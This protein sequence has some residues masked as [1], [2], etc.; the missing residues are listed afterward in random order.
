MGILELWIYTRNYQ[1]VPSMDYLKWN[2]FCSCNL[3]GPSFRSSVW[4]G[5]FYLSVWFYFLLCQQQL[6]WTKVGYSFVDVSPI[7]KYT[8]LE[9]KKSDFFCLLVFFFETS[10]LF[11]V[12]I[13]DLSPVATHKE[14]Q[15]W[16]HWQWWKLEDVS[17]FSFFP[18]TVLLVN[19]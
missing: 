6:F 2:V 19:W 1:Q 13:Y 18:G 4:S 7:I 5:L 9:R 15:C 11:A 10:V 3:I 16:L 14:V 12:E 17:V 8:S